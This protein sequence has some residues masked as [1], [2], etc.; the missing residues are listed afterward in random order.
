[1]A[2]P[3]C[4]IRWACTVRS[5]RTIIPY[6]T[7][8]TTASRAKSRLPRSFSR[9]DMSMTMVV[10]C[11]L[12]LPC[13]PVVMDVLVGHVRSVRAVHHILAIPGP[14][15]GLVDAPRSPLAPHDDGNALVSIGLTCG[16]HNQ[17]SLEILHTVQAGS[18]GIQWF[19]PFCGFSTT[20]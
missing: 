20:I 16:R 3:L 5:Y 9:E 13:F 12:P 14:F 8:V 6:Y 17:T 10:G 11:R 7:A 4:R 1:M 15:P 2:L 19:I 18:N